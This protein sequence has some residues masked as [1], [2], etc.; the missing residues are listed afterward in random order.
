MHLKFFKY[1]LLLIANSQF[2][3]LPWQKEQ[4]MNSIAQILPIHGLQI[5]TGLF[6]SG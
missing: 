4:S 2:Q 6:L 3:I 1:N 5:L